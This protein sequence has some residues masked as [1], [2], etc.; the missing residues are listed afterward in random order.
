MNLRTPIGLVAATLVLSACGA[1]VFDATSSTT[2]TIVAP[3]ITVPTGAATE[4]LPR[5]VSTMSELSSLIGFDPSGQRRDRVD[6]NFRLGEIEAIWKAARR[7]VSAA[8]PNTADTISRLVELARQAVERNRPA[9]ADKAAK[10]TAD[11]VAIYL[12]R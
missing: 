12:A 2:T 6:K 5:L 10:F 7:E 4:L 9:D 1:T 3:T 11:A 8:D